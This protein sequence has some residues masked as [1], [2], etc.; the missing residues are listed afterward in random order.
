MYE[1]LRI[2]VLQVSL[3]LRTASSSIHFDTVGTVMLQSVKACAWLWE[4]QID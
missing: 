3:P 1:I 4:F 2:I